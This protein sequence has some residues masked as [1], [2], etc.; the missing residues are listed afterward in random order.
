MTTAPHHTDTAPE[1]QPP[2]RPPRAVALIDQRVMGQILPFAFDDRGTVTIRLDGMRVGRSRMSG[3]VVLSLDG[4]VLRA[5]L[6]DSHDLTTD[7]DSHDQGALL[8]AMAT[9]TSCARL[10]LARVHLVHLAA[11]D[12]GGP[13]PM[14]TFLQVA[15]AQPALLDLEDQ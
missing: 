13:A 2:H 6:Y 9:A 10:A 14:R 4:S 15:T 12:E 3:T 5:D 1:A 11:D 7:P 8:R